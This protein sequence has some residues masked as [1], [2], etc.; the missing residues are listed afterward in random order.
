MKVRELFEKDINR[1]IPGVIT[2][3]MTNEES[4]L[5]EISEYVVTREIRNI[6]ETF[7][8]NYESTISSKSSDI[9]VWTTGFFGS[10]K[11]HL[12]KMIS[13]LLSNKEIGGV[14]AL[15]YFKDKINDDLL[16]GSILRSASVPTEAIIF[17]VDSEGPVQKDA[18]AILRVFA[19]VFY[20]YIGLFGTD[21]R[22]ASFEK[23]LISVDKYD[24]FKSVYQQ[25]TGLDWYE[26][27][28][29][30]LMKRL[31]TVEVLMQV[32]HETR[33]EAL[34]RLTDNTVENLTIA[35]LA[36]EIR[37]YINSKGPRNR[38]LFFVDEVGQ[39]IGSDTSLMLNLQNIVEE[40]GR[41][42][43]GRVWVLVTSQESIDT[44]FQVR[45][46]DFS[47]IHARF[48]TRMALSSSSVDEVI[49]IRIL[50]KNEHTI[51]QL[52]QLYND[53]V[54]NLKNL[55]VFDQALADLKGYR[56]KEDFIESYPFVPY[57]FKLLQKTFN[58]I[59]KHGA[60]GK[61]LGDGARTML[62]GFQEA[63]QKIQHK[64]LS[65][66]VP[67]TYFFDTINTFL[68]GSIRQVFVRCEDAAMNRDGLEIDD[69]E[70]LK[71]LFLVRY[72]D[73]EI[74]SNLEN[75]CVLSI[76]NINFDKIAVKERLKKS[77]DRLIGQSYVT[78]QGDNYLFL[79]DDE[80]DIAREIKSI[81]IDSSKI[82]DSLGKMIF[83]DIFASNK[84]DYAN[85]RYSF[86]FKKSLDGVDFGNTSSPLV[87]SILTNS[88]SLNEE[89]ERTLLADPSTEGKATIVLADQKQYFED[90]YLA[91]QIRTFSKTKSMAELT[92]S[93][94]R[95]VQTRQEEANRLQK[96]VRDLLSKAIIDGR[97]FIGRTEQFIQG[98][99]PKDK[100]ESLMSLL[101]SQVYSKNDLVDTFSSD[102]NDI[103]KALNRTFEQGT[104]E[105]FSL[106]ANAQAIQEIEQFFVMQEYKFLTTTL[107]DIQRRFKD[108]P[109]GFNE[110]DISTMVATLIN[111]RRVT[112]VYNGNTILPN[113]KRLVEY[114]NN[115]R[116]FDK[117]VLK[118]REV[119]DDRLLTKVQSFAKEFFQDTSIS[120]EEE[121]LVSALVDRL[122]KLG[123]K[124]DELFSK[125]TFNDYPDKEVVT[126][127]K[128][129]VYDILAYKNSNKE[130]LREVDNRSDDLMDWNER[131]VY[132][133]SFFDSQ[134]KIYTDA[135]IFVN[136]LK[137]DISYFRDHTE[138]LDAITEMEEVL[139]AKKPYSRIPTLPALKH[140]VEQAYHLVL[141]KKRI[142]S[143]AV[144]EK[145]RQDLLQELM[146][147][148]APSV[149][150]E[151]ATA[152]YEA[153]LQEADNYKKIGQFDSLERRAQDV[154]RRAMFKLAS[155][156]ELT[157]P[158][159]PSKRVKH[160]DR[161]DLIPMKIIQTEEDIDA[162]VEELRR[163][164]KHN[165][166]ENDSINIT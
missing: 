50:E 83:E 11:S 65:A 93:Q 101:I 162:L 159:A 28:S 88:G 97:Y 6:L 59:R 33:E 141:D 89:I 131:F 38:L 5:S 10:G 13:Y 57:Q 63:L 47:K 31:K 124:V 55:F 123:Q 99:Q 150:Q 56:T 151:D 155:I 116:E 161:K 152:E 1:N 96:N 103:S 145:S 61:H 109:Y 122:T 142:E 19:S 69:L 86:T 85:K 120:K 87:L 29:T 60:S 158:G 42:C 126:E 95:I 45:G 98:S 134:E 44:S 71:L 127:G 84:V 22:I 102:A 128:K 113:D 27:R 34:K 14:K 129:I 32:F 143:K 67:F 105:S 115:R 74:K 166:A 64:D 7:F 21:L 16:Y 17:N 35:S 9:G 80:Q 43:E 111:K 68:E 51:P 132:V 106:A 75:L 46:H 156:N 140:T 110:I 91:E 149:I 138:V 49:K 139:K 26:A 79:T 121:S 146:N 53:N 164:L 118:K 160:F 24:E 114:L 147:N 153:L 104:D 23:A 52:E 100:I 133:K 48:K 73:R 39:Y 135:R 157:P 36:G 62:S 78:R 136:N 20:N 125:Y 90:I 70:T 76:D 81:T 112:P 25:V 41:L 107:G 72:T 154:A 8:S 119:P 108:R 148:N 94:K 92:E 117:L 18:T 82:I 37:D 58:E 2:V 3:Q 165:L 66:L 77:L 54:T 15:E 144:I 30:M 137:E 40:L 4:I 12:L 163:K 130:F